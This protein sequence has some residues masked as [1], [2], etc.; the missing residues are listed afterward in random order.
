MAE[1]LVILSP[2]GL[3]RHGVGRLAPRLD[4]VAGRTIG[5]L[6]D[7]FPDA[8][9]YLREVGA[10]LA[11]RGAQ[12][13]YWLK[14]MLSRPAPPELLDEVARSCDAVVVGVAA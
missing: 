10:T 7:G 8:D 9:R 14:P 13:R 3:T 6:D 2:V 5:L 4:D 11:A 1:P 12:V